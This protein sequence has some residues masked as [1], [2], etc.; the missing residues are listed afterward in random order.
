MMGSEFFRLF[1]E[2]PDSFYKELTPGQVNTL[3]QSKTTYLPAENIGNQS[4]RT[5]TMQ[6]HDHS[7]ANNAFSAE[8]YFLSTVLKDV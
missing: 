2:K 8:E 4:T 3:R 6:S 5:S 1:T 7:E